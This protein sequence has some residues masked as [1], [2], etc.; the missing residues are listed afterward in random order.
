M[1]KLF[2]HLSMAAALTACH[3]SGKPP[4]AASGEASAP[5]KSPAPQNIISTPEQC[6][7]KLHKV[8]S[9]DDLIRQMYETATLDGCLYAIYYR[10]LEDIWGIPVLTREEEEAATPEIGKVKNLKDNCY[11]TGSSDMLSPTADVESPIDM[12][13]LSHELADRGANGLPFNTVSLSIKPNLSLYQKQRGLFFE[14][15]FPAFL[16]TPISEKWSYPEPPATV[17]PSRH[18]CYADYPERPDDFIKANMS[19]YWNING[20]QVY[21]Q[22]ESQPFVIS[23]DFYNLIRM[24]SNDTEQ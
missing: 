23:I 10:D 1:K 22:S 2:L 19:Y 3:P 5:K 21:A 6:R 9:R 15:H 16:G 8:S 11:L 24:E 17:Q 12:Y 20:R 18:D 13:V 4:Q 14:G 7:A